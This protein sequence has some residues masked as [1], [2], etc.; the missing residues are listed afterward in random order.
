VTPD[1]EPATSRAISIDIERVNLHQHIRPLARRSKYTA[2]GVPD[3]DEL[4]VLIREV[5]CRILWARV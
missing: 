3:S 5:L 4:A 2:M 1:G